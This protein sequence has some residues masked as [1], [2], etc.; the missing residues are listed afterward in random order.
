MTRA[1]LLIA[2]LIGPARPASS[3]APPRDL[4]KAGDERHIAAPAVTLSKASV[5]PRPI[6]LSIIDGTDI[7]FARVST[8]DGL[9]QTKVGQ[10]VQDDQGF[11][12]FG[13]QYGLNRYD[14]YT[15]KVFIHD[16]GNPNSLNGVFIRSLF[17][18]REGT[19]WVGCDQF[20]NKFDP[21]TETFTR[22]PVPFVTHISQ[23]GAGMLWLATTTG[24]YGLDRAT[25][26]I[27]HYSHDPN[28]PSSLSG[29]DITMSGED[30]GGRFW[31]ANTKGLDEFDRR[32]GKVT[33]RIPLPGVGGFRFTRIDSAYSGSL[34]S[35]ATLWL[36]LTGRRTR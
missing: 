18:D 11:M 20:V 30:K 27:R 6:Q 12:W 8:A 21:A 14:G 10:I 5:E 9:S 4:N 31:V 36:Y 3:Q 32:T 35:P 25:G 23:D 19:L 13:T 29:N 22:Y 15:F 34:T 16:P 33:L 17:K 2:F 26:R 28:D 7:R 24:L 1:I